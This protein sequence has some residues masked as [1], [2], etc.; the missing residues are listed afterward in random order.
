MDAVHHSSR[1]V[2]VAPLADGY[3]N[4]CVIRNT[5]DT[6]HQQSLRR[7]QAL[8]QPWQLLLDETT[9]DGDDACDSLGLPVG[10]LQAACRVAD[11]RNML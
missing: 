4:A 10:C 9:V 11:P 1:H 8:M 5:V 3:W 7:F 6:K 2:W